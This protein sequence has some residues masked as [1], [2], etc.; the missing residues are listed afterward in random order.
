[1]FSSLAKPPSP[2]LRSQDVE[3]THAPIPN[4]AA[5]SRQNQMCLP[6]QRAIYRRSES[7]ARPRQNWK[8]ALCNSDGNCGLGPPPSLVFLPDDHVPCSGLLWQIGKWPTPRDPGAW[9]GV[10]ILSICKHVGRKWVPGLGVRGH[11]LHR[12]NSKGVSIISRLKLGARQAVG[13]CADSRPQPRGLGKSQGA[14]SLCKLMCYLGAQGPHANLDGLPGGS[15][16]WAV[17]ASGISTT[18]R[19]VSRG[20]RLGPKPEEAARAPPRLP[21]GQHHAGDPTASP[22]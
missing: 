19:S 8:T 9:K 16:W 22:G 20:F 2:G 17:E 10:R 15:A 4:E 11:K 7:V 12:T 3:E 21:Q 18:R 1:M 6:T 14:R 13:N 5:S